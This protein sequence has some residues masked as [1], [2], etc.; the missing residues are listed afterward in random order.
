MRAV[1]G[2]MSGMS[3]RQHDGNCCK[4]CCYMGLMVRTVVALRRP[5]K[6]GHFRTLG[7]WRGGRD[8]ETLQKVSH[9][10]SFCLGGRSGHRM[11][12]GIHFSKSRPGLNARSER[13]KKHTS[14]T[15]RVVWRGFCW[16]LPENWGFGKIRGFLW[17]TFGDKSAWVRAATMKDGEGPA[18]LG[19]CGWGWLLHCFRTFLR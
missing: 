9:C 3:G 8:A 11:R 4:S 17:I 16:D 10:V 7:S 19:L 18:R 13:T 15:Y 2:R 5:D 14:S 1:A 12:G 6:T